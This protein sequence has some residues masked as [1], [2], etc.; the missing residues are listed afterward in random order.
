MSKA[1]PEQK[2]VDAETHGWLVDAIVSKGGTFLQ[3]NGNGVFHFE[4]GGKA[5]TLSVTEPQGPL[6][7]LS[8]KDHV[9]VEKEAE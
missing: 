6:Q 7:D 1:A 2:P 4:K 8:G 5:Y 9:H 3:G